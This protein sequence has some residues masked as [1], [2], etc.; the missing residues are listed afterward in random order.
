MTFAQSWLAFGKLVYKW[1]ALPIA[2]LAFFMTTDGWVA[3][4]LLKHGYAEG[5]GIATLCT[6][7]RSG[8]LGYTYTTNDTPQRRTRLNYD[9]Q[10]CEHIKPGEPVH[11]F[12]STRRPEMSVVNATPIKTLKAAVRVT[13]WTTLIMPPL[14][15]L[16][17]AYK[18]MFSSDT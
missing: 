13:L 8:T 1:G 16:A 17:L 10:L 9:C 4:R 18:K 14:V 6:C 5:N 2:L 3:L 12:Y 15:A 11:V 7:G